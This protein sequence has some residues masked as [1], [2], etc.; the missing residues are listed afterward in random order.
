M[1]L[2]PRLTSTVSSSHT[3]GLNVTIHRAPA[4]VWDRRGWNG[5][6]MHVTASRWLLGGGGVALAL[7][8]MRQ[9]GVARAVLTGV[10]GTLVWWALAGE[11]EA[12]D[13]GRWLTSLA[14]KISGL[15]EDPV[16]EASADSF[17]ASDA[18]SFTPTVGT[19]FRHGI[20]K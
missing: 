5:S 1:E 15:T 19:G 11:G 16:H 9:K 13:P 6:R 17:P 2:N 3:S 20:P 4:S 14:E 12:P 8:G 7:Q 18:P 10:G